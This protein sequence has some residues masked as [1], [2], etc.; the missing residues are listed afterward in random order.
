M[1]GFST[2]GSSFARRTAAD[3]MALSCEWNR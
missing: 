3:R 1:P 2:T